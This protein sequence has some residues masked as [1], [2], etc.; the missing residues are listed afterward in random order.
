MLLLLLPD[1]DGLSQAQ[2]IP[3][4]IINYKL[5]VH[6]VH[7]WGTSLFLLVTFL[8][9][10]AHMPMKAMIYKTLSTVVDDLFA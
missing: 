1:I 6:F 3:Q 7:M 4:L 9:S 5:K 10:V 2:L 8:Q